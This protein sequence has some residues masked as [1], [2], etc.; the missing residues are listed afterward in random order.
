RATPDQPGAYT[1]Q[2]TAGDPGAYHFRV[3]GDD[4]TAVQFSVTQP[5]QE[6]AESAMNEPL[7]REMAK[8]SG[9]EFLREEDLPSL[10]DKLANRNDRVR[11][12]FDAELWCS[13][14]FFILIASV[15]SAEWILR[16]MSNLK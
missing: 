3:E 1:G 6:F 9:G 11:T 12:E 14:L 4:K 13:P 8:I 15:V 10:P 2:F 16:K 5:K 7:L